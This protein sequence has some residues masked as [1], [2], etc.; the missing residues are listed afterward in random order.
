MFLLLP[1]SI[2]GEKLGEFVASHIDQSPIILP[3]NSYDC[4]WSVS[5][6]KYNFNRYILIIGMEK[7]SFLC[8][9]FYDL[10][11]DPLVLP[12]DAL[13]GWAGTVEIFH[14][15]S[16]Q[17]YIMDERA[18]LSELAETYKDIVNSNMLFYLNEFCKTINH[19]YFLEKC[20]EYGREFQYIPLLIQ[21]QR[22][23]DDRV[24]FLTAL[25]LYNHLAPDICDPL[26]LAIE[27]AIKMVSQTK[28]VIIKQ[29]LI[30][31]LEAIPIQSNFKRFINI[32]K[33][34]V[35]LLQKYVDFLF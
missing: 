14:K 32:E 17:I 10:R 23:A 19:P 26:M 34:N 6:K 11:Q 21:L 2:K 12:L 18:L 35:E 3:I 27:K 25:S 4:F 7:S 24:T 13:A 22:L 9:D 5:Y 16:S 8:R 28:N 20:R 33:E 30:D 15:N 31:R 29:L 1:K